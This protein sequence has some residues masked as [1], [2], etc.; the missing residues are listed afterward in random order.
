M[1]NCLTC[2]TST[3]S[4][5]GSWL[6]E[7]QALDMRC[8]QQKLL[9]SGLVE[10]FAYEVARTQEA[11]SKC[12]A[13]HGPGAERRSTRA[14]PAVGGDE[15]AYAKGYQGRTRAGAQDVR[16][17]DEVV[18]MSVEEVTVDE[19]ETPGRGTI[20]RGADELCRM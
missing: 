13:C 2:D 12:V 11:P 3:W 20:D 15:P 5:N 4:L 17:E 18:L 1:L 6:R 16:G 9:L 14:T 10:L 8:D 19:I 7:T